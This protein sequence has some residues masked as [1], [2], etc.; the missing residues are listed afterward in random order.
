M[1]SRHW[2]P[3]RGSSRTES[4]LRHM[5]STEQKKSNEPGRVH[6][7]QLFGLGY[8]FAEVI[9]FRPFPSC[10]GEYLNVLFD[11]G[12]EC[13]KV[14]GNYLQTQSAVRE[15]NFVETTS[16]GEMANRWMSWDLKCVNWYVHPEIS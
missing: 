7:I 13:L 4:I 3:R 2:T 12:Q 11:R 6:I 1:V 8:Q 16:E 14:V 5:A 10:C 9:V 15:Y